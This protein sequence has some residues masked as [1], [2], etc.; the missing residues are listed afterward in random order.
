MQNKKAFLFVSGSDN[1]IVFRAEKGERKEFFLPIN[2]VAEML[3]FQ[4]SLLRNL[5]LITSAQIHILWL[6]LVELICILFISI[7]GMF[8]C[9]P[10]ND[11]LKL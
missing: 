11:K 5:L 4:K 6:I 1:F 8:S 2:L 9:T 10:H 3:L 7:A